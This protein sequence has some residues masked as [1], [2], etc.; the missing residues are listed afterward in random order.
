M[1]A[2]CHSGSR[3]CVDTFFQQDDAHSQ[4]TNVILYVLRDVFGSHVLSNQFPEHFI[5][6]WLRPPCSLEMNPFN[7]FLW[8]C[9]CT[10]PTNTH[11]TGVAHGRWSCFWRDN[12][13]VLCDTVD[14]FGFHLKQVHRSQDL[15]FNMC[16]HEDHVHTNP[17]WKWTFIHV[18]YFCI[19]ENYE[20]TVHWNCC[21]FFWIPHVLI[22]VFSQETRR[23][24]I[25]NWMM[26]RT[27]HI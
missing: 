9:L 20:Y 2:F 25:L 22:L 3:V 12:R 6:V 14:I 5:C 18:S 10:A 15:I 26:A 19:L 17:P 13:Y 16:S 7:Y 27:L 21:M 24:R 11:C 4:E 1:R 23:Q 8:G